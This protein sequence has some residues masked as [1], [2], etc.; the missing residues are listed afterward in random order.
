MHPETG[1]RLRLYRIEDFLTFLPRNL[2]AFLLCSGYNRLDLCTK[3]K[4]RVNALKGH[5]TWKNLSSKTYDVARKSTCWISYCLRYDLI[6]DCHWLIRSLLKFY[7]LSF[8][9]AMALTEDNTSQR[10]FHIIPAA[11]TCGI[12]FTIAESILREEEG[13][14]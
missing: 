1:S 14:D 5:G 11:K 3:I 13:K 9:C 6:L 2:S 8:L 4:T 7:C 10:I 12:Y